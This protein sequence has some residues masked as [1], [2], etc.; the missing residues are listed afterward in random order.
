MG[1]TT[2]RT[3]TLEEGMYQSLRTFR[4]A[5]PHSRY[6]SLVI[7]ALEQACLWNDADR[8]QKGLEPLGLDYE[9]MSNPDNNEHEVSGDSFAVNYAICDDLELQSEME[10][11]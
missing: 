11:P 1:L 10:T 4:E 2:T 5:T 9:P 3:F 6:R 8:K 7:T